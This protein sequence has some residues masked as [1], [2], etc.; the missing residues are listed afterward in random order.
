MSVGI[1]QE[2]RIVVKEVLVMFCTGRVRRRGKG[3]V[4]WG[5]FGFFFVLQEEHLKFGVVPMGSCLLYWA[6][7]MPEDSLGMMLLSHSSV[8]ISMPLACCLPGSHRGGNASIFCGL[9]PVLCSSGVL[10]VLIFCCLIFYNALLS[11]VSHIYRK[12]Q[13]IYSL[14]FFDV[15]STPDLCK[16]RVIEGHSS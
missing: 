16:A 1:G 5:L 12:Y 3:D 11:S 10:L 15:W 2:Q 13:H 4:C 7:K 6:E 8:C 9:G 14:L